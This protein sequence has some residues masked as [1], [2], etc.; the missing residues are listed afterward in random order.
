MGGWTQGDFEGSSQ[1]DE[2]RPHLSCMMPHPWM[3]Q[4]IDLPMDELRPCSDIFH[5]VG[6]CT[7]PALAAL[8][9]IID[10]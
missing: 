10:R 4:H 3:S 5:L 1:Q 2:M 9:V 8:A 7:D 6:R